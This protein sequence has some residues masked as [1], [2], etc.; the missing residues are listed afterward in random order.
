MDI[1]LRPILNRQ[2]IPMK[3]THLHANGFVK[4]DE[5]YDGRCQRHARHAHAE[6]SYQWRR[7][8]LEGLRKS[9][10]GRHFTCRQ[11]QQLPLP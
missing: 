7:D 11:P 5:L 8:W 3:P 6:S 4:K 2:R 1:L 9:D 10:R